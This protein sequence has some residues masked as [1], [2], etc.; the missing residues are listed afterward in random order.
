MNSRLKMLTTL[1]A[2]FKFQPTILKGSSEEEWKR[3]VQP[4]IYILL[5]EVCMEYR[6]KRK[7]VKAINYKISSIL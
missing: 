7:S 5:C 6:T 3:L 2:E 4:T 1:S